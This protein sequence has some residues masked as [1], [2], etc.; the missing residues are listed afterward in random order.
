MTIL[1]HNGLATALKGIYA[2][3]K[4]VLFFCKK[5]FWQSMSYL[6]IPIFDFTFEQKT[7][8]SRM[9]FRF[10]IFGELTENNV[11]NFIS[12]TV[13]FLLLCNSHLPIFSIATLYSKS[14]VR[15]EIAGALVE[16]FP[17]VICKGA[18][19]LLRK[20]RQ[21]PICLHSFFTAVFNNNNNN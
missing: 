14:F 21:F 18:F 4:K 17:L 5:H 8:N 20:N 12:F 16:I 13:F 6:L 19:Q 3:V 7:E 11:S 1:S 2:V 9:S 15:D 10:I